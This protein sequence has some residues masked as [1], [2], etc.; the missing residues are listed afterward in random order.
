MTERIWMMSEGTGWTD[1]VNAIVI[2]LGCLVA[3]WLF[4]HQQ[5]NNVSADDI[6][7]RVAAKIKVDDALINYNK[8]KAS[9][10]EAIVTL[11]NDEIVISG[12]ISALKNELI[13]LDQFKKELDAA[14]CNEETQSI[15]SQFDL[16]LK[17]NEMNASLAENRK[18]QV[19]KLNFQ[20]DECNLSL[21]TTSEEF[22][23]MEVELKNLQENSKKGHWGLYIGCGYGL[24][25]AN[26]QWNTGWNVGI[27]VGYKLL[28][29]F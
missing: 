4:W 13:T 6:A 7:N 21:K 27:S 29:L 18:Q 28:T 11:K 22:S 17:S 9:V 19:E 14:K 20:I 3:V 12:K 15:L 8:I 1:K 23:E 5:K 25:E 24:S 16:C 26:G 10:Q 2:V